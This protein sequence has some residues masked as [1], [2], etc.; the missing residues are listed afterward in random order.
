M[1]GSP[2][3]PFKDLLFTDKHGADQ[4]LTL[5]FDICLEGHDSLKQLNGQ[6]LSPKRTQQ[7]RGS[8]L[9]TPLQP[10]GAPRSEE[11]RENSTISPG[12]TPENP[13]HTRF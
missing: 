5:V 1:L 7:I 9:A 10:P 3:G 11:Q 12:E 2:V 6:L 13:K 8:P 4:D